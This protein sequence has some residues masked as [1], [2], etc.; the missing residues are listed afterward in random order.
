MTLSSSRGN[1]TRTAILSH[2]L[3]LFSENGYDATS[4]AEICHGAQIS[5][6]A[7][8]Y[9]FP[10]KQDLFLALMTSW[11]DGVDG[12]FQAAGESALNVP[13]ALE[14]MA[15]ISGG[16]FEDLQ[17]GFPI[18]LE[19]WRQASRKPAIW[20]RAVAPYRRYLDFFAGI[21]QSGIEEG[22]FDQGLDS[23]QAARIL[24]AVAM[25]LL[26]Q[27]SF[28]PDGA[29]WQAVTRSG[30]GMILTGMRRIT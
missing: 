26:L 3:E 25:G 20:E 30:I 28:D 17:G 11:L 4:V 13:E 2:S 7:F 9:H 10:S 22:A 12:L 29:D 1:D 14:N 18:L 5:K 8:Y 15:V 27:A 19:F 23:E 16:I 21:I 6:G 24:M